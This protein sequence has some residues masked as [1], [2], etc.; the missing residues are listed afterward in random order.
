MAPIYSPG[1]G[2]DDDNENVIP[3]DH[4]S[5]LAPFMNKIL[6]F[7]KSLQTECILVFICFLTR[8]SLQTKCILAFFFFLFLFLFCLGVGFFE[9]PLFQ[10]TFKFLP[11]GTIRLVHHWG[12]H[13]SEIV[14]IPCMNETKNDS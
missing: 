12:K 9:I 5:C 13:Y 3:E 2:G 10:S 6:V 4:S 1:G 8:V 14:P 11:A 7:T